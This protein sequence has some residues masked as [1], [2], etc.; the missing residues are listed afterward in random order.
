MAASR[1]SGG[2]APAPTRLGLALARKYAPEALF[3]FAGRRPLAAII[4]PD[5]CRW[6]E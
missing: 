5:A 2:S 3:A 6:R 4:T 1:S